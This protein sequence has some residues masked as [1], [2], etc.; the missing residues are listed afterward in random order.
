MGEQPEAQGPAGQELD[1]Y[2]HA[3]KAD[4]AARLRHIRHQHPQGPFTLAQ[5]A[6]RTGLSKRTLVSAESAE[7]TNLT[8]ETLVKVAH[9]LGIRRVAYFLDEQVF[10]QVNAELETVKALRRRNVQQIALR[11]AHPGEAPTEQLAQLLAGIIDSAT[12]ARDSLRDAPL[13]AHEE[14]DRSGGHQC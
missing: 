6:E 2:L 14:Q 10:Q 3:T 8:L 1:A 11:A 7:G 4:A 12:Q 9:S 5:L 13:A